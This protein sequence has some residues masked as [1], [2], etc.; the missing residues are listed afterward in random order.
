MCPD[1][2]ACVRACVYLCQGRDVCLTAFTVCLERG[3]ADRALDV[4]GFKECRLAERAR[5]VFLGQA[6]R[7]QGLKSCPSF[8]KKKIL[9]C[10]MLEKNL[11]RDS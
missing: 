11:S 4:S 8:A 5:R 9:Y 6:A 7:L 2:S 10:C 3:A 1:S